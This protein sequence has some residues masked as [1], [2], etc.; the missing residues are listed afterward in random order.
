[1]NREHEVKNE[2]LTALSDKLQAMNK[3]LWWCVVGPKARQA[4]EGK[5]VE[6]GDQG[7]AKDAGGCSG[8]LVSK[9]TV[10]CGVFNRAYEP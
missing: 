1:M 10:Y 3:F 8:G 5:N 4:S 6:N 9:L 7:T 2:M